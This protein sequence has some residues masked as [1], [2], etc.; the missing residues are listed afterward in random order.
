MSISYK[1]SGVNIDAGNEAV[2]RIKNKV[3]ATFSENVI[4]G[5][6][7]FGAMF[8]AKWLK[9]YKEPILVQSIDG[10]GTKL[11]V[12]AMLTFLYPFSNSPGA[13]LH[14]RSSSS[15]V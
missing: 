5:L 9:D 1:Q 11:K 6:G 7:T 2:K 13:N 15:R 14:C 3:K 4:T 10:V 8:N 12:A